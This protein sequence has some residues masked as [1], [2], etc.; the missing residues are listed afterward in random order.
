MGPKWV[1]VMMNVLVLGATYSDGCLEQQ[2]LAL[3]QLKRFFNDRQYLRTWTGEVGSDC[4][5]WE[6]VECNITTRRVTELSLNWMKSV[7]QKWYLNASLF[8]PF[9]ELRSLYLQ[10]NEIAGFVENEGFEKLSK[11]KHLEIL[12]LSYN[13]IESLRSSHGNGRQLRL[14]NLQVLDLS[15]NPFNNSILADLSGF[16]NLKSLNLR[17]NQLNGSIDIKELCLLS[18]LETLDMSH[19]EVN[20]FVTFKELHLLSNVEDLFMDNTPLDINFLQSIGN[21]TSLK[22]LSLYN[23]GLAGTLPSQGWCHLKGLEELSLNG[24]G[25]QG[26]I[27]SCLG[28]STF[29]RYL[30]ISNNQFTGNIAFTA[31]SNLTMLQVL[32]LSNNQFQV[33]VS[34][35]SFANH[36][37][38]KI[39]SSNGNRLAAEPTVFQTWSPKF[40]LKVL[41]LSN[42]TIEEHRNP[43]L[44]NFL[45][46]QY[47]LRYVDLSYSNFVGI[48]FPDWLVRNNTRLE[49]LYMMNSSIEG[50]LF[51]PSHPNNNMRVLNISNNKM[52]HQIPT[53]FCSVFPNLELLTMSRNAFKSNIPP[54][55]GV[56]SGLEILDI[57]YNYFFGGIPKELA[58][59]GSLMVLVLSKNTLSGKMFPATHRS[60]RL[61]GLYLD[62]NN[63]DGEMPHFSPIISSELETLDLSNNHL[64]GKLPIWLWNCTRLL[65]LA[66][67]NNQLD[68]PI[69]IELCNLVDL[70][71]LDLSQNHLSGTIPSCSNLQYIK[72]VHLSRNKL[73]GPLSPA[74]YRSSSLVTLDLSE[75]NFTGKFPDW[76]HTLPALSVLLLKANQ[77]HGEFPLQLRK[78]YSLSIMDLS[79]NKLSGPIPSCFSNL[80][81]QP[82]DEK[83]DITKSIF[84]VKYDVVEGV[85]TDMGL[86]IYHLIKDRYYE[87]AFPTSPWSTYTYEEEI[88][89]STK[90]SSYT[91][92]GH[93]LDMFSGFDLS[94]NQLTGIIPP[95]LGTL[96]EIRGLN[97]SHN[98]LTGPIPSTFSKL[99]QIESLDLSYNNLNGRIPLQLIELNFLAVF[100]VAHNNLSG[101]LPDRKGQFGTFDGSSY[102]GNYLLCGPPLENSCGEGDS[103][104]TPNASSDEDEEDGFIDMV[105]FY[106][107]LG[108]TFAIILLATG[109]IALLQKK[110]IA[111]C[112]FLGYRALQV[113]DCRENIS[114]LPIAI[115][116]SNKATDKPSHQRRIAL[117][118]VISV[119]VIKLRLSPHPPNS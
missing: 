86:K 100:T 85:L 37:N 55:L 105:D 75:N 36:S 44:P 41:S 54:C 68:G 81:L 6:F 65:M 98:N 4:C 87:N 94:C 78:L 70:Q 119:I 76:I 5:R 7:N 59:S 91:Y 102:E 113:P 110:H 72:H 84:G 109:I 106:D 116:L 47:D 48:R 38:L 60:T 69:P 22:I 118:L 52:Q 99:K 82:R 29:L 3:L 30:D 57:S 43:Q 58:M 17:Q 117:S 103:S 35:K 25:L 92:K 64:S 15:D 104:E 93:I 107:S 53:N 12:D 50:P 21:L 10:G 61:K 63:F 33:P 115:P 46:Y 97:L 83:S 34:F 40:Q 8:L 77:F 79:Q 88:V 90:R 67:A 95:G 1:W 74:F 112:I 89:I 96:A 31:L 62:G 32:S 80:T 27:A 14:I 11:L 73:S 101:P 13:H 39:L 26:A 56:M 114:E 2:R 9:E 42:C 19:N 18:N 71:Y 108:V 16:S 66:L 23:C 45:Y 28:N 111:P 20:Q 24:N 51:L 49:A